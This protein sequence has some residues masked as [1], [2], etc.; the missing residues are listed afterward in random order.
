MASA[1]FIRKSQNFWSLTR[2]WTRDG[3]RNTKST[4]CTKRIRTFVPFVLF[5]FRSFFFSALGR[6][7]LEAGE[8][9]LPWFVLLQTERL[10]PEA[11]P[12]GC[13]VAAVAVFS[14]VPAARAE[15]AWV[16]EPVVDP[17]PRL[18]QEQRAS[19]LEVALLP[20][21]LSASFLAGAC[22]GVSAGAPS[23][24]D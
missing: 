10:R 5:V 3:E 22:E 16:A 17:A 7:F 11:S 21:L 24:R 8:S 12:A 23:W 19:R 6:I 2:G 15:A 13:S 18:P 4:K 9:S 1:K 20:E 14:F